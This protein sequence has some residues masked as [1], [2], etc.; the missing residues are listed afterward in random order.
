[1]LRFIVMQLRDV[2]SHLPAM[3]YR[4]GPKSAAHS[5]AVPRGHYSPVQFSARDCRICI[6]ATAAGIGEIKQ[7]SSHEREM[8]SV[9]NQVGVTFVNPGSIYTP[10]PVT[11]AE[12]AG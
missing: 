4:R 6:H 2:E 9:S 3:S 11:E 10:A 5:Q 1:M 12:Q 7:S 8:E